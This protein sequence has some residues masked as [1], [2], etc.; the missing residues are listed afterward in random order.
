MVQWKSFEEAIFC[1]FTRQDRIGAFVRGIDM[2][3][4]LWG[5]ISTSIWQKRH[6]GPNNRVYLQNCCIASNKAAC[7]LFGLTATY[8]SIAVKKREHA[9][10]WKLSKIRRV[11]TI[12]HIVHC[13]LQTNIWKPQILTMAFSSVDSSKTISI[14]SKH[15]FFQSINRSKFYSNGK[16]ALETKALI[17]YVLILI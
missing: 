9:V 4:I 16:L 14:F 5:D 8:A 10:T 11:N 1:M 6:F 17:K 3:S 12:H 15:T 2:L 7:L 13:Y